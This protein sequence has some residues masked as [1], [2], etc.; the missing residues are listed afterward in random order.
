MTLMRKWRRAEDEAGSV[1]M[2]V[3]AKEDVPGWN[4]GTEE[5]LRKM[6]CRAV[7]G[8]NGERDGRLIDRLGGETEPQQGQV[9]HVNVLGVFATP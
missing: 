6:L 9:G 4:M 2:V 1:D 7:G 8:G 5:G 3:L